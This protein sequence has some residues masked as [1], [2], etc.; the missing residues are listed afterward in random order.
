MKRNI[1]YLP[2]NT[3]SM[4]SVTRYPEQGFWNMISRTCFPEERL[5]AADARAPRLQYR[6]GGDLVPET[7]LQ[8]FETKHMLGVFPI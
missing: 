1:F 2:S 7:M 5:G 8:V 3:W 4:V 6:C